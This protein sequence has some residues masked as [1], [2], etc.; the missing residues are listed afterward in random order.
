MRKV[1]KLH[2]DQ[3]LDSDLLEE[4]LGEFAVEAG[5][6]LPE[7]EAELEIY[8]RRLASKGI[9]PHSRY[10]S[11]HEALADAENTKEVRY[12]KKDPAATQGSY[13]LAAR[14]GNEIDAETLAMMDEAA[15][16]DDND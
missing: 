13:S 7:T 3:S 14:N 16:E 8:E 12:R 9:Q 1:T 6:K 11:I 10:S 2:P 4:T 15:D 5:Y